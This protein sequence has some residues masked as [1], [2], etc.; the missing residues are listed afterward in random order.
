M[1]EIN[2]LRK[3]FL[4]KEGVVAA[5][6]N[7]NLTISA[8]EFF[9]LLGPS[10]SG[11][12][13]LL[14]CLAGIEDPDGGAITIGDQP[15][16]S[17]ALNLRVPPEQRGLGMVFQSYAVWPHLTVFDNVALPLRHGS[18]RI[19]ASQVKTQ[20]MDALSMVQLENFADRPVPFLS[21]GQQQRVALAR[22]LAIR[23]KV[24]LM[25]EPLSNLDARLREEV[26]HQIRKI[27]R[28]VGVTVVYVTHDQSEALALAD[29]IAVMN[30]GQV[31]QIGNPE[32]IY[33]SPN[34]GV[35]ADFFGEMNWFEGIANHSG[36]ATTNLGPIQTLSAIAGPVKVGIRPTH[37]TLSEE[38]THQ[39]N[40]FQGTIIDE[41]FLGEQV[42][43]TIKTANGT[44]ISAKLHKRGRGRNLGQAL[45]CRLD[46][47]DL[48]VYPH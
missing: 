9:V 4:V 16:Y 20:V 41:V 33:F 48:F 28:E 21:G 27:T 35:V 37:L 22:A 26:R 47:E 24:M 14:R 5:L 46:K 8:K 11:K 10:G 17:S 2:G 43:Y 44:L 32:D 45:W 6:H 13:T 7:I 25:D 19:Q 15:I 23:P 31:V 1:I 39:E 42:H 12:S 38:Q 40:E 34:T 30:Q 18:N 29:R 36:L 3:D